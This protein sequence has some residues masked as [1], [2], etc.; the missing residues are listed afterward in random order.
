MKA[1]YLIGLMAVALMLTGCASSGNGYG[2]VDRI[3][4]EELAKI[5]PPAVANVSLDEI[6]AD[7][8]QGKTPDEIIAKIAASNSRYEL[9]PAQTLDL[10]KQGVDV[11]VLDYIY[12]SN[13]LAKQN[14]IAEEINRR[15][16]EN[17][18]T[19]RQLRRERT[20][21]GSYYYGYPYYYPYY[22]G[23]YGGYGRGYYGG[24][25]YGRGR[26]H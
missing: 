16:Q 14:A 26:R 17:L 13:E 22:G 20:Y 18:N 10:G 6:V 21:D 8:K 19:Q 2:Q 15:E 25:Y 5:L 1:Y 24:G 12:Q 3:T 23:Y 7:S 9:T 4:P 11:K